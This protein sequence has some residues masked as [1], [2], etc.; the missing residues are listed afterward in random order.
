M[1]ALEDITFPEAS[2]FADDAEEI[3]FIYPIYDV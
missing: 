2:T 1:S 3:V